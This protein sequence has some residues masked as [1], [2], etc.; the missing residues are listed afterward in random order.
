[1]PD[2]KIEA[3][4]EQTNI[5]ENLNKDELDRIGKT[6]V[7]GY[8]DDVTSR[9]DWETRY[10]AALELAMQVKQ[11]KTTPW[12]K[13]ANV[14]YPLLT[15]AAIQFS[16][17]A[18]PALI[19]TNN[20]VKGVV[21]GY[22]PDGQKLE[23]AIRISKH[24][25]YQLIEE[26][27]TWE[28]DMDKL[29]MVLPLLGCAFKKTYFNPITAKNVSELVLPSHL[30]V[31]YHA[32]CLEDAYRVTH[33]LEMTQNKIQE[34]I[35]NG[36]FLDADLANPTQHSYTIENAIKEA[37]NKIQGTE[38]TGK[39]D[40]SV[41]FVILEQHTYLDLDKDGYEEPY[42]VTVDLESSKVL[43]IAARFEVEGVQFVGNEILYIKPIHYFTKY[44]FIPSPDGG[45]Y[46][47]GF[48]SLL[49]PINDTINTTINQLLDAGTLSTLQAGFVARGVRLP[50]GMAKFSPGE[51]KNVSSTG[52]D[53][54]KGIFPLPIKEPSNVLFMLLN[55]MIDAGEK[56]ANTT[57]PQ[58]GTS[59]I[60]N[61]KATTAQI[62]LQQ[63]ERVFNTIHKRMYRS[64]KKELKK[65]F[66]LNALYLDK[67]KYFNI[68]DAGQDKVEK[69]SRTDYE[70][71]S[72]DVIPAADPSVTSEQQKLIKASGL[73]ELLQ[74]GL[75]PNSGEAAKRILEAQEQPA[76]EVLLTPPGPPQ[77]S[78]E[79]LKFQDESKRA[80]AELELKTVD[81]ASRM[82]TAKA[83]ALASIAK[84]ESLEAGTQID[85]YKT[86][87]E[88]LSGEVDRVM[89][90][91][92][93]ISSNSGGTQ[94]NDSNSS[95]VQ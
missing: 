10:A 58:T 19:P 41:P 40:G 54:R 14:K 39:D 77:P 23:K 91:V 81:A 92:D 45:F 67:D 49:S 71:E 24:M 69:V 11:N 21:V 25:S 79:E 13:A 47:V 72:L 31:D 30:V 9:S 34:R 8:I 61:Q 75:I 48:G 66:R 88:S 17:R 95:G 29:T 80:W 64:L 78:L 44:S 37:K 55:A 68:L 4:L 33:V 35:R 85:L 38:S 90:I 86:E 70:L 83:N 51:W 3:L 1:M 12:P 73:M 93:K 76:V 57:N 42:V 46:D 20:I 26:M 6:V 65:L 74:L 89:G 22:D 2:T 60:H 63:G 7:E 52:E 56:L 27:D 50:G 82:L 5:A 53:L 18:Y 15:S 36:I 62:Q 32:K 43:R 28:E 87:L 84:A 94:S 59:E 16:S